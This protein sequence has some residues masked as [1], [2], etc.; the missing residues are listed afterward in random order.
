MEFRSYSENDTENLARRLGVGMSGR[1]TFLLEGTLGMGK[2]VFAR[3][4]IRTL[5][6]D[7]DMDVPSPTFTLLQT[8]ETPLGPLCHFDLYRLK[9]PEEIFELGWEEA[10]HD[11]IV[12]VEWPERLGPYVP[13]NASRVTFSPVK[14]EPEARL[15][16]VE[17]SNLPPWG[18]DGARGRN[19]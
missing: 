14:D 16:E 18:E 5:C 17:R 1:E 2:S 9:D 8:Y 6:G 12:L 3:S 19:G 10:L 11:G 4:L 15:I 7:P 13:R